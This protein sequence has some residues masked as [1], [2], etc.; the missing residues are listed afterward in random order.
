MNKGPY[1]AL[2]DWFARN[3]V[4]ANL[5]MAILL[6]GGIYTVFTIKKEIQ[7]RIETNFISI[8]V[9]FLGATPSDAEEGV[10]IK[11]EEAI[12]DIEGIE[13]IISTAGRGFGRVQ[14]EVNADYEVAEVMDEVKNRVDAISTFPENTEK[15]TISRTQFQQQVV[16]V[17]VYGDVTQRRRG[18]GARPRA[19]ARG[20]GD[21]CRRRYHPG[22]CARRADGEAHREE[23]AGVPVE[24]EGAAD[25]RGL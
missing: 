22:G 4:A 16:M 12:Q 15:P 17:T 25:E 9:P 23:A 2:I 24:G 19:V 18:R 10:V 6:V 5:L 14:V 11:I 8:Q 7:P 20:G 3:A 1:A 21:H 13:E